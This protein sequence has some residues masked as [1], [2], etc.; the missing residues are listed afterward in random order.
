MTK[1]RLLKILNEF[2]KCNVTTCIFKCDFCHIIHTTSNPVDCWT[3]GTVVSNLFYNAYINNH[4]TLDQCLAVYNMIGSDDEE[5]YN[6]AIEIL[7][8][9]ET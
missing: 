4:L 3:K 5:S 8:K 7:K 2:S 6:L 1:E 9:Y